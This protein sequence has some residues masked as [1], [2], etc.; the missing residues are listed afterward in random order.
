M[1]PLEQEVRLTELQ[2]LTDQ[3]AAAYVAA[4][5]AGVTVPSMPQMGVRLMEAIERASTPA[6]QRGIPLA[7]VKLRSV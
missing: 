4:F 6:E 3:L 1:T 5:N 7:A 2:A